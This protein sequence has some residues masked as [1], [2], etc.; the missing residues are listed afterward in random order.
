MRPFGLGN[1]TFD[2]DMIDLPVVVLALSLGIEISIR[3]SGDCEDCVM[4]GE[5]VDLLQ[6]LLDLGWRLRRWVGL[7]FDL[8]VGVAWH[9]LCDLWYR[10]RVCDLWSR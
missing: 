3:T 9:W 1:E 5:G 4:G 2:N 8:R 10:P 7:S 6:R